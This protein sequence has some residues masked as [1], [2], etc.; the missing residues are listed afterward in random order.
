MKATL[1]L[2]GMIGCLISCL[3][4]LSAYAQEALL[5]YTI[6]NGGKPM[7]AAW[8]GIYNPG[9]HDSY[10]EYANSGKAL[11]VPAGTYDIGIHYEKDA[12]N[13]VKWISGKSIS[14]K[15]EE[16]FELNEP[17]TN[18]CY[19]ITNGG[20]V[21][22]K[23][24]WWGLHQSKEDNYLLYAYS[25]ACLLAPSGNYFISLHHEDDYVNT[26]VWLEN[27]KLE[28]ATVNKSVELNA[29][30][31]QASYKITN[32]GLDI[33]RKA[34]WG[35]YKPGEHGSY[36]GYKHSGE[37]MTIAAGTYD[38]GIEYEDD[39][40]KKEKW[41]L[42]EKLEG[43]I[44]KSVELGEAVSHA[45]VT[46]TNSGVDVGRKAWWGVYK[47][48]EHNS[49]LAYKHSGE[50]MTI[51][52]GSYDIK[53]DFTDGDAHEERWLKNQVFNQNYNN[54][55]ELGLGLA[56]LK[57][58]VTNNGID[59]GRKAW[60]GIYEKDERANY[61]AYKLSGEKM[62]IQEG[63]YDLGVQFEDGAVRL[64]RWTPDFEAKGKVEKTI[65]LSAGMA[66]LTVRVLRKGKHLEKA[67]C[68]AY[69][70]KKAPSYDA[71]SWSDKPMRLLIGVYDI[72]CFIAESGV[73]SEKWLDQREIK[74]DTRLEIEMDTAPAS[75]T[76]LSRSVSLGG[77][78]A[79]KDSGLADSE[80]MANIALILD[81]SGSMAAKVE[82]QK[83]RLDV[84]KEVLSGAIDSLPNN[85]QV[86]LQVYGTEP[87][88]KV[89]CRDSK[90]FY[91][92]GAVNA[93]ALKNIIVGLT[94]GGYTPI[95]YSLEQAAA[96]LPKGKNNSLI[97]VTDGVESC[98]GDPCAVATRLSA[99]GLVTRSFVV[100]FG[101]DLDK[102]KFLSCVGKYYPAEDRKG[103]QSALKEIVAESVKPVTGHVTIYRPNERKEIITQGSLDEKLIFPSGTYDVLI[104]AGDKKFTWS[105]MEIKGS[106]EKSLSE[107]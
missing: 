88:S 65:E 70:T 12:V 13:I 103:L 9:E 4:P 92:L 93:E 87:K 90:V 66:N 71:H 26:L 64:A 91:P 47:Q 82:N 97:L 67:W 85:V 78:K 74:A 77:G 99:E 55:V 105:A 57:I 35:V 32:G 46:I 59:V 44:E 63:T 61:L 95:A 17:L 10:I 7:P 76:V 81:S 98:N 62:T 29:P 39:A 34:W 22:G 41:L 79:A 11:K 6:T 2:L 94:P 27:E 72:G 56:E 68:G 84:A 30:V 83:T 8:F 28:G 42:N 69:K 51:G 33:G 102:G 48:G 38:I 101:L 18:V 49:Y 60:W 14:A 53:I 3:L 36:L 23:K 86:S 75:L 52:S 80:Q 1:L 40:L 100:G 43:S 24:A 106:L 73:T 58:I 15:V 21:V 5:T 107:K 50:E 16:T 20:I 37:K 19:T 31:A 45:K 104:E 96:S 89:D 54:T 25:G